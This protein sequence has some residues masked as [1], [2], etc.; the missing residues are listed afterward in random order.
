MSNDNTN[1]KVDTAPI[2]EEADQC[3]QAM[4]SLSAEQT[5]SFATIDNI[6]LLLTPRREATYED[7]KE[8]DT[9]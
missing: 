7:G 9:C 4:E 5:V 8:R 6:E 1:I 2:T 3:L